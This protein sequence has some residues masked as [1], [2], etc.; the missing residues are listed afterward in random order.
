MNRLSTRLYPSPSLVVSIT[1][2]VVA[3]G[4]AGYSATGGNFILGQ[5]NSASTQTALSASLNGRA[6]Q[7]TNTNAGGNAAALGLNV[8]AGHPPL[9]VNSAV[10]VANLNADKL[11]G[12]NSTQFPRTS[13]VSFNLAPG[14]NSAPIALPANRPVFVMGVTTT[15][16]EGSVGQATLLRVPSDFIAWTGLESYASGFSPSIAGGLDN[17]TGAHIVFLD[18]S[19]VVDIEVSGPDAIRIHNGSASQR[20]G[21]LTLI[22]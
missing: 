15:L 1:A 21:N 7:L 4:G 14:E 18:Y 6:L 3:L 11:D 20:A 22:W 8:A 12:L 16:S 2:L 13:V 9:S 17:V 10:K 5:A 19:H